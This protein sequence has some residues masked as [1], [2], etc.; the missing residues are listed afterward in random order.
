MGI[1]YWP[2]GIPRELTIKAFTDAYA[3][4]GYTPCAD[5]SLEPGIE[6]IALF[7]VP[8]PGGYVPTHAALQ[9][10]NGEWTSKL[11]PF[12]DIVHKAVD[13]VSGPVYGRVVCYISHPRIE[14]SFSFIAS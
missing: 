12:E 11:G 4:Q 3:I 13:D 6:K 14:D 9:L 1:G 5:G 7:A 10:A 2:A 8:G